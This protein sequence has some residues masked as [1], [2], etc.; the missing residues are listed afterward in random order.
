MEK[1]LLQVGVL[2]GDLVGDE[3]GG[4]DGPPDGLAGGAVGEHEVGG[5]QLGVD[6]A[7]VECSTQRGGVGGADAHDRATAQELRQRGVGDESAAGQHD[8]FVDGLGH[9]GQQMAGDEHGASR[10]GVAA[11][12]VAQPVDAFGVEAV[13]RLVQD[14]D[15]GIAEERGGEPEPLPHAEREAADTPTGGAL[16]PDLGEDLVD[17]VVGETGGG[18]EDAQVVAGSAAGMEARRLEHGAD[19]TDRL[20]EGAI[21]PTVDGGRAG[22]RGDESEQQPQRRGLAGAVR[23]RGAR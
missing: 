15:V 18:G 20:I 19:V 22:G 1:G 23:S 14:E 9:L 8:D 5:C 16:Q 3:A 21:G 7:G 11:Q 13:G 4:G 12:E 6:A 2:L 10:R 17:A